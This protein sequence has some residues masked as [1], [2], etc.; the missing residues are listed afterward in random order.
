MSPQSLDAGSVLPPIPPNIQTMTAPILFGTLFNWALFGVLCIQIYIYARSFPDDR[1][2]T[3]GLVYLIFIVEAVQTAMTGADMYFWF[4]A[5]FGNVARLANS[6]ISPIDIPFFV[7][8]ISLIVQ[9]FFCYRIYM[10]NRASWPIAV[11]ISLVSFMQCGGGFYAA[12]TAII[13]PTFAKVK[14]KQDQIAAGFWLVG[15]AIDDTIIAITMTFLLL[16]AR[17]ERPGAFSNDILTKIVYLIVETNILTASVSLVSMALIYALPET[18][19][20]YCPTA[21]MGKLYSNTLLVTL[22]NRLALRETQE[23]IEFQPNA[24]NNSMS[25]ASYHS[26]HRTPATKGRSLAEQWTESMEATKFSHVAVV[27]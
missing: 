7:S 15:S 6:Y 10:I 3:K 4:M 25:N 13:D 23:S 16:S 26:I 9:Q 21:I 14:D 18:N 22:N 8:L 19:Y 17:K 1:R 27:A 24:F 12:I 5:G 11:L 20:F 2:W